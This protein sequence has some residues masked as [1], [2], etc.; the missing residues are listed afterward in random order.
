MKSYFI[1][2]GLVAALIF[3][4]TGESCNK[5]SQSALNDGFAAS[6]RVSSFG[7]DLTKG[8]TKLRHDGAIPQDTFDFVIAKLKLAD[9]AGHALNKTLADLVA[10]YPDGNIPPAEFSPIA[11][12]FNSDIYTPIVDVF[13]V[14]AKLSPANQALL[15]VSIAGIKL[16]INTIRNL[17]NK[18]SAELGLPEIKE[19]SYGIA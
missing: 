12:V 15:S 19:L 3:T 9:I 1:T 11:L 8:F 13:G 7:T 16:A 5:S 14:V 4:C 10:K 6:V 18:H 17:V 2:L